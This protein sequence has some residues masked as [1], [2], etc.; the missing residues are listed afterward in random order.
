MILVT[1][2]LGIIATYLT[3]VVGARGHG[4]RRLW[5]MCIFLGILVTSAAVM[6]AGA[7][8]GPDA[9]NVL[10]FGGGTFAN[11]LVLVSRVAFGF[12]IGSLLAAL[13]CRKNP[14]VEP[15]GLK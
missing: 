14:V 2:V 8:F 11:I 4:S 1:G 10:F 13:L 7:Q 9:Q 5:I 12:S 6:T 3:A 15:F